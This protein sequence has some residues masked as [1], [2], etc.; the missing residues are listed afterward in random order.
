AAALTRDE[1]ALRQHQVLVWMNRDIHPASNRHS[2]FATV[3]ALTCQVNRRERRRAHAVERQ[4]RAVEVAEIRD[5]VGNG[6]RTSGQGDVPATRLLLR[7]VQLILLI[8]DAHEHTDTNLRESF[9]DIA[10]VFDRTMDAL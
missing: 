6:R 7:A 10:G 8:H 1:L 2:A 3:Q 4:A 9:L 5:A